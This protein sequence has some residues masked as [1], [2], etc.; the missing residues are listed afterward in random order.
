[1]IEIDGGLIGID[2]LRQKTKSKNRITSLSSE[3]Y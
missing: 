2:D 1:M 3:E